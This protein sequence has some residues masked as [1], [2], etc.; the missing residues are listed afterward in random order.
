MCVCAYAIAWN[1]QSL[2]IAIEQHEYACDRHEYKFIILHTRSAQ[3]EK[4][5][6]IA[7]TLLTR[8]EF[9]IEIVVVQMVNMNSVLLLAG[10]NEMNAEK[11]GRAS[12]RPKSVAKISVALNVRW[13]RTAT[14]TAMTTKFFTYRAIVLVRS[15]LS[16]F[17]IYS[18]YLSL[19]VHIEFRWFDSNS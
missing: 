15:I 9:V 11:L 8:N 16:L 6:H 19:W 4:K 3:K 10:E 1:H 13:Q 18:F 17:E 2:W 12:G 5:T 7:C 14:T